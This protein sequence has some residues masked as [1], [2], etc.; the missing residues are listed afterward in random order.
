[1]FHDN[2]QKLC[3]EF[4]Y[5]TQKHMTRKLWHTLP[6]AMSIDNADSR[7]HPSVIEVPVS[8]EFL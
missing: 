8:E 6:D 4:Q 1:M 7:Y 3:H 2:L 5:H